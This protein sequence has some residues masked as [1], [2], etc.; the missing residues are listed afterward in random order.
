[1]T[2]LHVLASAVI[3][4][5]AAVMAVFII[6]LA[7]N[8]ALARKLRSIIPLSPDARSATERLHTNGSQK[9]SGRHSGRSKSVGRHAR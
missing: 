5:I 1:M 2:V 4:F 6:L 3:A 9:A 8:F 7:I